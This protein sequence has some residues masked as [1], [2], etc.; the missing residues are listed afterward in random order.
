MH[1]ADS[2][3][4]NFL[5]ATIVSGVYI[6]RPFVF[7]T[8]EKTLRHI[9]KHDELIEFIPKKYFDDEEFMLG[10]VALSNLNLEKASDR[11]QSDENFIFRVLDVN[12]GSYNYVIK[13]LKEK[14]SFKFEYLKRYHNLK[15]FNYLYH[16]LGDDYDLLEY[17][18][19]HD[20]LI[21]AC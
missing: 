10:A 18:G 21:A 4:L 20:Q 2:V 5:G 1:R 3:F 12:L 16:M 13:E 17:F 8:R 15:T 11:L 7:N 9:A 14:R 19:Y 6:A